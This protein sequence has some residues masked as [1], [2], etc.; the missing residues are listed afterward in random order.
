MLFCP[1][2]GLMSRWVSALCPGELV[3]CVQM[4][5]ICAQVDELF[6]SR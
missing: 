2:E 4:T 1:G 6:V 3:V 5:V